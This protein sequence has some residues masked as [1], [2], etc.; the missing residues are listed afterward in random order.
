[1]ANYEY[2]TET[3][4]IVPN[5]DDIQTQ[6]ENE[7]KAVFGED[8]VTTPNTPQGLLITTDVLTRTIVAQNNA[9]LANQINPNLAGGTHLDAIAALTG[10][11]RTPASYSIVLAQVTGVAGTIIPTAAVA[12]LV[13]GELFSPI[14]D[15]TIGPTGEGSGLFQAQESGP[16]SVAVGALSTIV[17]GVSGWETV[18]NNVPGTLGGTTESDAEFRQRRRDTLGL[19]GMALPEAITSGLYGAGIGVSSLKFIENF[20]ST[21]EVI[22]GVTMPPHSIYTCVASNTQTSQYV[23]L[24]ATVTGTPGTLIPESSRAKDTNDVEYRAVSDI[25]IGTTGSTDGVFQ[26]TTLGPIATLPGE[27]DTIVTPVSGWVSVTNEFGSCVY[28]QSFLQAVGRV[29]LAKKS[30]GCGWYGGPGDAPYGSQTVYITEPV[31]EQRCPVTFGV[32]TPV[33]VLVR[34]TV[35]KTPS[36]VGDVV[37]LVQNAVLAYAQGK[38]EGEAGFVVGADVSCFEIAGAISRTL[39]TLFVGKVEATKA[40]AISYS[41]NTISINVWEIATTTINGIS[42]LVT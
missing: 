14:A 17:D 1:M 20:Y 28:S 9:Q 22:E 16:I 4:V 12:Q 18:T 7:Y 10:L 41:T 29:L 2:I 24:V 13:T 35:I 19:Q 37:T 21:T 42:V 30:P 3:G 27:L 40:N 36:F 8:L 33:P 26:A 6:V 11:Q 34:V 32:P 39:P 15:I 31:S 38:I 5:T 25:L 23:S